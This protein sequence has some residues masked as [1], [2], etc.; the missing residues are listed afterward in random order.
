MPL[1]SHRH[2]HRHRHRRSHAPLATALTGAL[3]NLGNGGTVG[4]TADTADT[5]LAVNG[6]DVTAYGL[7]VEHLRKTEVIWD[8]NGGRTYRATTWRT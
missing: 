4:W 6:A 7:F 8:G 1:S 2:R 3:T 5:G